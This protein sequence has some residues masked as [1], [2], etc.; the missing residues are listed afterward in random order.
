MAKLRSRGVTFEEY[1]W[2]EMKT[3]DGLLTVGGYKSAWFKDSEGNT[4]ELTETPG[5]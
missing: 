3:V 2:G 4:L 5:V 1:D